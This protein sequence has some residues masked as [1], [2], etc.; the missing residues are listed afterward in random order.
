MTGKNL[1]FGDRLSAIK[2]DTET[3]ATVPDHR[4]DEVAERHGFVTREPVQKIV[5]RKEAEPS[6]NLNIRPPISTYNRFVTW[7]MENRLSYPE[8]LKLLMDKAGV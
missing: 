5:R 7:A 8:A 3:E 1:G 6:A 2:P 4:I